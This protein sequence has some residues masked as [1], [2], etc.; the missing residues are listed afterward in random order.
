[1]R[2][3][4]PEPVSAIEVPGLGR[5]I[6]PAADLV[7][8]VR[9]V[10]LFRR[11]RPHIVHTHMAK[12]GLL[13]RLAARMTSV[14]V[15]VHTFHGN[16]LRGYFDPLRSSVFVALE[17]LLGRLSNR[18]IAISPRQRAEILAFEIAPDERI[19]EIPLGIDLSQF[20]DPPRGR[21]RGEL[22][23]APSAP[24]VGIIARLVPIKGVDVFLAAAARLASARPAAT[25][26]VV[27]DGVQRDS[28]AAHAASLGIADRVRFLGWR[29]DLPEIY[30]DLDVVVLT[31]R[32]EGTPLSVIEALT[33][34]RAVVATAVGGVP[35]VI[36]SPGIGSLV[37]PEDPDAVAAAIARLLDDPALRLAMGRAGRKRVYPEHDASTL[38]ARVD[39]LYR[40]LTQDRSSSTGT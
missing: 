2:D 12:A 34:E 24:L 27:G 20:L 26:V 37:P 8:L 15:I 35:D 31:S 30:A 11:F 28:L 5:E 29:A 32:N 1:M 33:T 23:L 19:V 18:V 16:V 22:G 14:P 36:D 6:S 3:V 10:A 39:A 25:F 4:R 13:G 40:S 21:L 7:A 38:V 9:L 17:R